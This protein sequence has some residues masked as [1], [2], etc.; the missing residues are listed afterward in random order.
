MDTFGEGK[1]YKNIFRIQFEIEI[2]KPTIFLLYIGLFCLFYKLEF[3]Y[4]GG[5]NIYFPIEQLLIV[6]TLLFILSAF[7]F[8]ISFFSGTGLYQWQEARFVFFNF[9]LQLFTRFK[10]RVYV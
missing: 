4:F 3:F 9:L 2:P 1:E 5:V 6:P 7:S 10:K 8:F